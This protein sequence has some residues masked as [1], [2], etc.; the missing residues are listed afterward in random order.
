MKICPECNK[1]EIEDKYIMCS[2]CNQ[3]QKAK[4]LAEQLTTFKGIPDLIEE[5]RKNH[6]NLINQLEKNN[7]NLYRLIRQ[8]DVILR[9]NHKIKI[10]WD[11]TKAD[12][13]ERKVK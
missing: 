11:K 4:K 5:N 13:I 8:N 1:N 10:V 12:F 2:D 3:E 7:N 6:L 9:K